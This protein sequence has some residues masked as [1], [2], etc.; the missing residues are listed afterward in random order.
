MVKHARQI[1]MR[2]SAAHI[3][4]WFCSTYHSGTHHHKLTTTN[5]ATTAAHQLTMA[6]ATHPPMATMIL[7]CFD[8]PESHV[9]MQTIN[10]NVQ[11]KHQVCAAS[12]ASAI[13]P[14]IDR[15]SSCSELHETRMMLPGSTQVALGMCHPLDELRC[16]SN[17]VV[18]GPPHLIR[19]ALQQLQGIRMRTTQHAAARTPRS[20]VLQSC[21]TPHTHC[22]ALTPD[23]R[24][25]NTP[26]CNNTRTS[27]TQHTAHTCAVQLSDA[28]TARLSAAVKGLL[29]KRQLAHVPRHANTFRLSKS[30]AAK[31]VGKKVCA[32]WCV[33][34]QR[35]AGH[36]LAAACAAELLWAGA[37]WSDAR[38]SGHAVATRVCT[39]CCHVPHP[40]QHT[41]TLPP[42][43]TRARTTPA[44]AGE[45]G[46]QE[47]C[48]P[49]GQGGKGQVGGAQRCAA[50]GGVLTGARGAS[51][52]RLAR[53]C[54]FGGR[55]Q[56]P[57]SASV[58]GR[59][60]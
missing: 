17:A 55:G 29:K 49:Q 38:V 58:L 52:M 59:G 15:P 37:A 43:C 24:C 44:G 8:G 5:L 40:T 10:K 18:H 47:A 11:V 31:T 51:C 39:H 54:F 57:G 25:C 14:M 21:S 30:I 45:K 9:S 2:V 19:H 46:R 53:R 3:L 20:A 28:S 1:N 26:A 50:A 36:L 12:G 42:P 60:E 27:H 34:W 32:C 48:W 6:K 4:H 13:A 56:C 35:C 33:A 23:C 7:E 41:H 22:S 16:G